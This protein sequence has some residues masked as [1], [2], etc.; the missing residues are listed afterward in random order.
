MN[1]YFLYKFAQSIVPDYDPDD[2]E[3]VLTS[4]YELEYKY[5]MLKQRPFKGHPKR[6]ENIINALSS[7]LKEAG[8][9]L[10]DML[11]HVYENWL[12]E[13]ALLDPTK[14]AEKR[15]QHL[16]GMEFSHQIDMIMGSFS[17]YIE[18]GIP[19]Y[20]FNDRA[21]N[22]GQLFTQKFY[23]VLSKPNLPKNLQAFKDAA[24]YG[25]REYMRENFV[26]EPMH[27]NDQFQTEFEL[28]QQD[29]AD[30][31]IEN[32]DFGDDPDWENILVLDNPEYLEDTISRMNGYTP[33]YIDPDGFIEELYAHIMFPAWYEVW[34]P[35]GIEMTRERVEKT[36]QGLV[37]ANP[38]D[39]GNFLASINMA[40][41]EAHQTGDMSDYIEMAYNAMD[42]QD[43]FAELTQGNRVEE[44][45]SELRAIGVQI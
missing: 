18:N 19:T 10:K 8:E 25:Q 5:S 40:I 15:V 7:E 39:M 1:W 42:V 38:D 20:R 27:F 36:F 2:F 43:T 6:L 16:E 12:S 22:T 4:V 13:H 32:Y 3:E 11:V 28:E 9:T 31:F 33:Y 14:W 30:E 17:D 37:N 45:N 34:A 44:W 21:R 35:Q 41:N 26:E 29:E 24:I 23:E